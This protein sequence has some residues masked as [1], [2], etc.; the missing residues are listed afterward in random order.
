MLVDPY[1][2]AVAVLADG[3][4]SLWI[5]RESV[6]S[7]LVIAADVEAA[8]AALGAEHGHPSGRRPAVD[9]IGVR[10]AEQQRAVTC[11]HRA[12]GELEA[13]GDLLELGVGRDQLVQ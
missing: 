13:A 10:R 7:G 5:E 12:L 1:H 4:A 6:R 9:R 8:V 11:P 3:Q 2:P